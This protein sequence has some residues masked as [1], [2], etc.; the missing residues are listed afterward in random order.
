MN[1]QLELEELDTSRWMDHGS[2]S[3]LYPPSM[4]YY[5]PFLIS[6]APDKVR[7]CFS[8]FS[9]SFFP[10]P[11]PVSAPLAAFPGV[12]AANNW[13]A[14]LTLAKCTTAALVQVRRLH[15]PTLYCT[16]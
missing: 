6:L 4:L 14:S 3:S 16:L 2:N 7:T 1:K 9:F 5:F 11:S 12:S 13:F 10:F 8:L 15:Y